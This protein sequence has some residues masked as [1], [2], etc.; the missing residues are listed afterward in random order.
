MMSHLK[1]A[2]E[3]DVRIRTQND[4][5]S[6][7]GVALLVKDIR[8]GVVYEKGGVKVTAFEVDHAPV[9][10]AF[11]YRI[12]YAGH[13]VVL[14]GDTRVSENLVRYARG[15]DVL[16]HEVFAPAT[17]ERAGVPPARAKNIVDYHTTPEQAGEV[18]TRVKPK[19]AVYSH[20][21]MPTATEQDLLPATRKTYAGPLQLG[22]D[23][24]VIDVSETIDVGKAAGSSP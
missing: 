13:S 17:L 20:I 15:V 7:E 10:P 1:Q 21:C 6:P 23:L 3:Y 22:E 12:D 16:V 14:S 19:L 4:G 8:E 24:M 11:G 9:K 18:F 5:A 2:Y